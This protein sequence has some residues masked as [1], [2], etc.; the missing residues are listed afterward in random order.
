MYPLNLF[1]LTFL[2]LKW[3]EKA[4]KNILFIYDSIFIFN[5]FPILIAKII[6]YKIIV[7]IVED[8][9][10][11]EDKRSFL[12]DI[13]LKSTI[14]FENHLLLFADQIIVISKY[15]ENKF[16]N[17]YNRK[18]P[19]ILIPPTANML[20]F[21]QPKIKND[22]FEFLY[23]GTFRKKDGLEILVK[24][25]DKFNNKYG[26]SKLVLIGKTNDS[27]FVNDLLINSNI[28]YL[29]P[30]Y[31]ESYIAKL[32]ESNVL[33]MTRTASNFANAGFPLKLANIFLLENLLFVLA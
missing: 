5:A 11:L 8:Y 25:F 33:C 21:T 28:K 31:G 30:Y 27:K 14:F 2:L 26:N 22:T 32:L 7:E 15:L 23:A 18:I 9:N 17:L 24:A 16:N 6:G 12:H 4:H 13:N 1:Y 10:F 19:I 20:K 3:K 29:G